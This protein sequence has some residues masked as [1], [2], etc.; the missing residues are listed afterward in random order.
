MTTGVLV[1]DGKI[2][3]SALLA[4][5]SMIRIVTITEQTVLAARRLNRQT[6]RGQRGTCLLQSFFP[7]WYLVTSH[8]LF[9]RH[10]CSPDVSLPSILRSNRLQDFGFDPNDVR[11]LVSQG[12]DGQYSAVTSN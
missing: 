12:K 3:T 7:N 4:M 11:T 2:D 6:A 5:T 1:I 8:N 9:L 10:V